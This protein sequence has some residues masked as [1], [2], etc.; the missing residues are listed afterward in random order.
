MK[1]RSP[2]CALVVTTLAIVALTSC[3]SV[4]SAPRASP[5]IFQPRVLR[6]QA[7]Q[8]VTTRDGI[9]RPQTDEVWHSARAYEQLEKENLNLAAALAQE[10][11]R[12]SP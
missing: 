6:L 12:T 8:P 5:Q 9:Y 10:R 3:A 11:N 2:L 4:S 1:P 7:E